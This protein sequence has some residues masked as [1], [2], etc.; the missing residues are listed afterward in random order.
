MHLMYSNTVFKQPLEVQCIRITF[1]SLESQR[2]HAEEV[3]RCFQVKSSLKIA[4]SGLPCKIGHQSTAILRTFG[5]F[6]LICGL[7]FVKQQFN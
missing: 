5:D 1:N 7:Q 3:A 6:S 2:E 4:M